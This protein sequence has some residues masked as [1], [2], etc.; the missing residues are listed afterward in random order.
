MRTD[1]SSTLT[2]FPDSDAL[3][4]KELAER[5]RIAFLWTGLSGYLAACL[6]ALKKKNTRIFVAHS[7]VACNAPYAAGAFKFFDEALPWFSDLDFAE[8]DSSLERFKPEAIVVA[9]WNVSGYRRLLRK[10][11]GRVPR[12]MCMDNPWEN[13]FR[14]W[15][16]VITSPFYV[17]RLC[18]A[19]W[20]PGEKQAVFAQHLGFTTRHI[21]RGAYCCDEAFSKVGIARLKSGWPNRKAFLFTGRFV[22]EKGIRVLA[23]AYQLY[24]EN[25]CEPWPLICCGTGPEEHRLQGISGIE[26]KGFIQPDE[27]PGVF[28]NATC[29]VLPSSVEHWGVVIHEAASSGLAILSS[30]AVGGA[31]HLLQDG[32][33]GYLFDPSDAELLAQRM[34]DISELSEARLRDMSCASQELSRQYTPDRWA[35]YFISSYSRIAKQNCCAVR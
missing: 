14:Q 23:Q 11:A 20:V 34:L 15:L 21:L 33:N 25:A 4:V 6:R 10:W 18:D 8:L 1:Q 35:S 9:S 17:R 29:F 32:Y 12:I 24:R 16:G 3:N 28:G 5:R 31:V 27:L 13:T 2:A 22:P 7:A 19:V 30:S 26:V